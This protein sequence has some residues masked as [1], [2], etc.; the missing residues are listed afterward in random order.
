V[1]VYILLQGLRLRQR[2]DLDAIA[3]QAMADLD[4]RL[5]AALRRALG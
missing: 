2:F 1:V 4:T 5:N 3:S